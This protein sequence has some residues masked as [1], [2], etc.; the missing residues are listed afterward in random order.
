MKDTIIFLCIVGIQLAVLKYK[1][2]RNDDNELSPSSTLST[3][4]AGNP[5]T[6]SNTCIGKKLAPFNPV[7]TEGIEIVF[8]L[9]S[10]TDNDVL[11]DL[12][13][14]DA[15]LLI[16]ACEKYSS[17]KCRG[18][19]YDLLIYNKAIESLQKSNFPNSDR[20][21]LLHDNVLNVDISDA[22]CIFVYLVPEG[23]KALAP[24]L[25]AFIDRGVR[26]VTY[27]KCT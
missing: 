3:I 12:G 6:H 7:S 13:C 2:R 20:L 19:E 10:L 23:M 16:A 14:G 17:I 4:R 27:G 11:Y 25:L 5:T 26:V 9:L 22:T 24:T 15:R 8:S 18:I 1:N 21:K